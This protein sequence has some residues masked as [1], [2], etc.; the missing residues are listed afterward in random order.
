[1]GRSI[2]TNSSGRVSHSRTGSTQEALASIIRLR[3]NSSPHPV[4]LRNNAQGR[5]KRL[6]SGKRTRFRTDAALATTWTTGSQKGAGA[7]DEKKRVLV[8]RRQYGRPVRRRV[9]VQGLKKA[10]RTHRS[11]TFATVKIMVPQGVNSS[12]PRKILRISGR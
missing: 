9:Q 5:R 10:A 2:E 3:N 11:N 8:Y 12:T 1:M 6:R 7:R 4:D